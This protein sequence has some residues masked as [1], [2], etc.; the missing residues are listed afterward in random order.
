MEPKALLMSRKDMYKGRFSDLALLRI[1]EVVKMCSNTPGI[2]DRK[3]F[4]MQGRTIPFPRMNFS[5]LDA[6]IRLKSFPMVDV[7]AMGRKELGS[8]SGPDLYERMIL[9][10]HHDEGQEWFSSRMRENKVAKKWWQEGRCL[11]W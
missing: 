7:K 10:M 4:C 1:A 3:P 5:N 9:P 2:P 6:I 8:E 11:R